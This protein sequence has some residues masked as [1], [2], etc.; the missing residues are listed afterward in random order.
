MKKVIG[1]FKT[2]CGQERI[3][4]VEK[5]TSQDMCPTNG[6]SLFMA[7]WFSIVPILFLIFVICGGQILI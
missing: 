1:K 6:S 2:W 4:R 5:G 7:I 3:N